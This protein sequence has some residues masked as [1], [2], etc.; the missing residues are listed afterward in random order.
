ME[1]E[2]IYIHN[3]ANAETHPISYPN[4]ISIVMEYSS[5]FDPDFIYHK[6]FIWKKKE[7]RITRKYLIC[8]RYQ[9]QMLPI[10]CNDSK[11]S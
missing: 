11:I 8:V 7:M 4:T 1:I 9:L 5:F 6:Q 2:L 3:A 10:I